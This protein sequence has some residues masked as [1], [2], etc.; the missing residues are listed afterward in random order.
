MKYLLTAALSCAA[1]ASSAF[2]ADAPKPKKEMQAVLDELEALGAKPLESL[3]PQ[4]ARTQPTPAD[5]VMALL[6]KQGKSTEPEKVGKVEDRKID[7]PGGSI[8]VRIYWPAGG[9]GPYPVVH[10]IHGGGWVIADLDVYDASPRALVN[11]AGAIVVSSHY[12][13]APE[14]PFPAA[15][16]DSLAAYQW[17]LANAESLGGDPK[18]VAVAGESAGGN[19][20]AAI[21][22]MARQKK[23]PMPVHQLLV[24]PVADYAFDTPSYEQNENA[25]PLG[26]DAMEWF[27]EQYLSSEK[28]GDNPLISLLHAKDLRGLPPATVITAEIDPL[29]SEG[30]Q[31]AQMLRKAGVK[32]DYANYPGVTHEFFG[33]GAVLPDAKR[34]VKQAA[35]GLKRSFAAAR[36]PGKSAAAG[37]TGK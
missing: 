29:R 13:Q 17:V 24:Y 34:A 4:Q 25:K 16:E 27:F 31:Y 10:Y 26:K 33:M 2:A 36:A 15:H 21:T 7:G 23:L 20:A 5:A 9:K 1:L 6:K 35:D 32:V 14:H 3:T 11:A 18:R 8:P 22:L 12:R 19:M 37:G 28:D 30:E